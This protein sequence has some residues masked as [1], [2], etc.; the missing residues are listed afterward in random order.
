MNDFLVKKFGSGEKELRLYLLPSP[1]E[2][3][4][5]GMVECNLFPDRIGLA[6]DPRL[7]NERNYDYA[8][9]RYVKGCDVC[10]VYM[11]DRVYQ[12]LKNDGN[13]ERMILLHELGHFFYHHHVNKATS[14]SQLDQLRL[15]A[16]NSGKIFND[17]KQA[18]EF[19][20]D[21]IGLQAAI[22]GLEQLKQ[23]CAEKYGNGEYNPDEV[24]LSIKELELRIQHLRCLESSKL[25]KR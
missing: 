2:K 23:E 22:D 10:T 9:L 24:A 17:E 21:Y 13:M 5:V 6:V 14:T 7:E 16:I 19:A 11:E 3:N 12:G 8:C 18:D 20:A 15:D 25:S 4:V 1:I